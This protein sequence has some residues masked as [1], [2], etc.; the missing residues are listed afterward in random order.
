MKLLNTSKLLTAASVLAFAANMN[1]ADL[2]IAQGSDPVTIYEN[3]TYGAVVVNGNLTVASG[4]TLTCTSRTVADGI[5]GTATL[6]ISDNARVEV[7]GTSL[8]KIGI[9]SGR[10]EVVMGTNAYFMA[11]GYLNFCY[12]YDSVPAS[13]A[14]MTEALLIVG[15]NSTVYCG[16]DFC[17]GHS[18]NSNNNKP[19]GN[20]TTVKARVRLDYGSMISTQRIIDYL[21]V[22]EQLLFNGGKIYQR[23]G[24]NYSN[25]FLYMRY[26]AKSSILNLEGTNSCPI[27]FELNERGSFGSFCLYESKSCYVA[28]RGDGGS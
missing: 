10:A 1:A 18:G 2:T 23:K 11:Q 15:S 5:S 22:S 28:I 26:A 7:S 19:S 24:S 8:T 12:G 21:P 6:T 4:V 3:S 27:A 14:R 20:A 9:G 17:F 13:D 16:T 25:G